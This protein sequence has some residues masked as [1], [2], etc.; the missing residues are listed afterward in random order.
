MKKTLAFV[1]LVILFVFFL[2][3][4]EKDGCTTVTV[5][6]LASVD[7]S[8]MT[9]HTADSR[10]DRTW[11]DM[12][13]GKNYKPGA[14]RQMWLNTSYTVSAHDLS[15]QKLLGQIPSWPTPSNT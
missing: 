12:V 7:G 15:K 10:E 14:L 13:P 4:K 3:A 6:K 2:S 1:F 9:S 11:I 5:G 8:V